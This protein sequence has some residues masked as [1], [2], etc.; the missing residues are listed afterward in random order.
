MSVDAPLPFWEKPGSFAQDAHRLLVISYHFPPD[1]T[2]GARRWE[3]LADAV[4]HRGWGLDVI[5]RSPTAALGDA[6]DTLPAG[7][8]VF[9]VPDPP[10]SAERLEHLL[11]RGYR[12]VWPNRLLDENTPRTSTPGSLRVPQPRTE[13]MDR[14]EIPRLI[15]SPRDVL[16]TYWAWVDYAHG[17]RWARHA[18]RLALRIVRPGAHEVV[19]TS[20]PPHMTH[21]SGRLVSVATGLPYVMDMRDPWSTQPW[22]PESVASAHWYR[23]AERHE[24]A[25]VAQAALVV[26]NTEPARATLARAHADASDRIITVMNGSDSDPLPPHRDAGQFSIRYAG[27]IY[28]HRDP[29]LL[30]RAAAHVI[31]AEKLTPAQFGIGILGKFA[32]EDRLSMFGMAVEEGIGD[33][34]TVDP[35]RPHRAALEFLSAAT[36]LVVFPGNNLLAIPAKVFEYV[37]FDS[38]LL[39]IAEPESGI[40]QLLR[41]TSADVVVPQVDVVAAAIAARY[42]QYAR[43]QQ[44]QRVGSDDRFSRTTQARLLLDAIERIVAARGA[45]AAMKVPLVER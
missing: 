22:L 20:A 32:A 25:C 43:G 21:E 19:I 10:L 24:R 11:W 8:R 6:L 15:R 33:F 29:Q 27:T 3:K 30:F 16:R 28:L 39:A 41:G 13:S 12:K 35:P 37:R 42:R 45:R 5:T 1:T 9:G 40:A 14:S 44:P 36:M 4:T 26:A 17:M 38:W 18:A 7:T 31:A 2:I 23:R 34:V